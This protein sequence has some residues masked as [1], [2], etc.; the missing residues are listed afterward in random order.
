MNDQNMDLEKTE[1][2]K[3]KINYQTIPE[4]LQD[5]PSSCQIVERY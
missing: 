2:N 3:I 4:M 1:E 5:F